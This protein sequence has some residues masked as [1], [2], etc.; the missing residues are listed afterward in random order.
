MAIASRRAAG[1]DDQVDA[2]L[3]VV[4]D[5]CP[6]DLASLV[7]GLVARLRGQA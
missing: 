3:R 1:V 5:N 6:A 2:Q 4:E 7:D